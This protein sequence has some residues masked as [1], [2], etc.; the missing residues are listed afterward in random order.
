MIVLGVFVALAADSWWAGRQATSEARQL[1]AAM[2][3]E[4]EENEA[5]L[6]RAVEDWARIREWG[7]QLVVVSEGAMPIPPRDSLF[8]MVMSTITGIPPTL[9]FSAYDILIARGSTESVDVG[10]LTRTAA[11]VAATRTGTPWDDPIRL[12]MQMRAIDAMERVGGYVSLLSDGERSRIGLRP[13][14]TV[15]ARLRALLRDPAFVSAAGVLLE[16]HV[17]QLGWLSQRLDETRQVL[18]ELEATEDGRG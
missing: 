13:P 6:E 18:R 7:R 11:L 17:N 3:A 12:E 1:V 15:D 9:S 8:E 2:R 16:L 14:E 4:L 5:T 10:T